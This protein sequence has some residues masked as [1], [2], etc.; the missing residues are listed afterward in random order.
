MMPAETESTSLYHITWGKEFG[1]CSLYFWGCNLRC[2]ICL[3]KQEILDCH[4]PETRLRI[5]E[6][7]SVSSRPSRFL[8]FGRTIDILNRLPI[9]RVFLMGGEPL[10][11]PLLPQIL[12][13]LRW[14]KACS[15]SLLTNGKLKP[16]VQ[17]LDEV[18][19]SIKA[20]TPSLHRDYTGFP[21]RRIVKNFK[22]LADSPQV[23][24]Y[25]E[26]VFIPDYVGES[27]V[28][29]IAAFIAS[30]N[31]DIPLRIDAYLPVPGECWRT[32]E[33][34]ELEKLKDRVLTI[35][36]RATCFHGKWGDEP[37]AY[38]VERIF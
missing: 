23:R 12:E 36:P 20:I 28:M 21:N 15:I 32:P 37:L 18:I 2:R 35:L 16:P 17:M 29:K 34:E 27:E 31:P 26:T 25:V 33:V 22:Q 10:C 19:F 14:H 7:S 6:A 1:I 30:I 11:E 24:L 3:L 4:L 13:F 8:T 38:E 9:K 5:Y